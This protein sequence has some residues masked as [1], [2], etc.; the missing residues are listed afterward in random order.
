[1]RQLKLTVTADSPSLP[2]SE[3]QQAREL[4]AA[5]GVRHVV[6]PTNELER[7]GYRANAGDRCYHCK[8][9]LFVTVA[10][11]V[12]NNSAFGSKLQRVVYPK[13]SVSHVI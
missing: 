8:R 2:R 12:D 1:M 3:L 13:E 7:P 5:I 9:E 6:L 4:A 11:R 10:A